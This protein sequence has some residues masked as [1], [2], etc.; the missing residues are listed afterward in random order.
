MNKDR[1][2]ELGK[3]CDR[4]AALEEKVSELKSLRDDIVSDLESIRDEE[5]DA[6]DNL[7]ESLQE[8]ERGQDMQAAIENMENALSALEDI[9]LD[10]EISDVVSTIDDARGQG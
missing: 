4:V 7:P 2:K 1:R 9:G 8:G 10:V 3:L 5:Q 6:Y